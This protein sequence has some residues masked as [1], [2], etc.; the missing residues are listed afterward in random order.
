MEMNM[1][2]KPFFKKKAKLKA[3]FRKGNRNKISRRHYCSTVEG[4]LIAFRNTI[5]TYC[6]QHLNE[7]G[8]VV[9]IT[10]CRH[11]ETGKTN[12]IFIAK[13]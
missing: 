12:S 11:L 3:R 4:K 8:Q 10:R 13:L 7:L 6:I 1:W 5:H 9:K 2:D